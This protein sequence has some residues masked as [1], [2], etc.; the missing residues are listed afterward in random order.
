MAGIVVTTFIAIDV[1]RSIYPDVPDVTLVRTLPGLLA[2]SLAASSALLLTLLLAVRPLD[3]ARLRLLPGRETV[4]TLLAAVIGLLALGQALDSVTTLLG[5]DQRGSLPTIRRVLT[6]M[7]LAEL[8][9]TLAVLGVAAGISEEIFFRGYMQGRLREFWTARTALLAASAAF[10]A[11]H[12]DSTHVVLA[13]ALG[14]YLGHVADATGSALPCVVC[15]I[16]N[17]VLFTLQTAF[18][19]TVAG[20]DANVVAAVLGAAVFAGCLLWLPRSLGPPPAPTADGA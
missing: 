9:A 10:A 17:N 11:L 18:G 1:L 16:A 3:A 2:G 6:G 15:H 19:V 14:L 8:G 7:S 12:L 13:L 5:L 4:L 20:R